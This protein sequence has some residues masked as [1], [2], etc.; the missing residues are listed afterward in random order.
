MKN[1]ISQAISIR[2]ELTVE[3]LLCRLNS[4]TADE[5]H[6]A[7]KNPACI[8]YGKI[9]GCEF[10]IRHKKYSPHSNSPGLKGKVIMADNRTLLIVKVGIQEQLAM[11]KRMIFPYFIFFG[12]LIG[13]VSVLLDETRLIGPAVGGFVIVIPFLQIQFIKRTL[14]SMQKEEMQEFT[15]LMIE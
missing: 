7:V 3:Q 6:D 13:A 2:T 4:I 11:I 5:F 8:Y 14:V 12:L 9:S 15:S 1:Q 10:D